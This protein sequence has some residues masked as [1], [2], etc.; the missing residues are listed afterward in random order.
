MSIAEQIKEQLLELEKVV[1]EEQLF[2]IGYLIPMV[3]LIPSN[4]LT[5]VQWFAEFA[6][7]VE[8]A[9]ESDG[10]SDRDVDMLAELF[11]RLQPE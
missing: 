9:V 7:F 2:L 5:D 11:D 6:I 10:L 1:P 4:D 8:D 3:D